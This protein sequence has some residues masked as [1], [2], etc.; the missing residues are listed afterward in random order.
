MYIFEAEVM[1]LRRLRSTALRAR[2][3]AQILN[4]PTA[5]PNTVFSRSAGACWRIARTITGRLLAHP[6]L[7]YQRGP[8]SVRGAYHYVNAAWLGG[9]A[10]FRGRNLQCWSAQL[11]LVIRE[12][13]DARALTWSAELSDSLGRFQIQ[14]RR[15]I[16]EVDAEAHRESGSQAGAASRGEAGICTVQPRAGAAGSWP[17]LAF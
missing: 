13:D 6:H 3:L 11:R 9:I 12:L 15:L 10:R 7:G 4:S 2:A 8:G 14:V 16:E 17:Y 5:G 1:R